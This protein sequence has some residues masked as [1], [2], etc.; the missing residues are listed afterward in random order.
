MIKNLNFFKVIPKGMENYLNIE[1]YL[2]N[3]K[4]EKSLQELVKIRV[5]QI[6]GCAYCLDMHTKDAVKNGETPQRIY[7]LNAWDETKFFTKRE[8]LALELAEKATLLNIS[9]FDDNFYE[10]LEEE[11]SDEE[12]ADLLILIAQIN[13]WNKFNVVVG[14]DIDKNL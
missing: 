13:S 2:S 11:F 10:R 4:I 8:K 9:H 6:N 14:N 12:F 3:S 7:L 1:K 5:S